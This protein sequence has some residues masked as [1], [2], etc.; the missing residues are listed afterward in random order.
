MSDFKAIALDDNGNP[1]TLRN[2][3][4]ICEAADIVAVRQVCCEFMSTGKRSDSGITSAEQVMTMG[5]RPIGDAGDATHFGCA[6]TA[7]CDEWAEMQA[8]IPGLSIPSL[9]VL[10]LSLEEALDQLGLEVI[11]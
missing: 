2:V 3:F 4:T 6:R 7:Y 9:Q 8:I 5:L 11:P 1:M 10:E